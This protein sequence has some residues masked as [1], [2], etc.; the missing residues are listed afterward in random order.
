VTEARPGGDQATVTVSLAVEPATAFD[1]FTQ[2]ID[3]WWGRG[4]AY[5]IFGR[6]PGVLQFERRVGGRL[7]EIFETA[8][9]PQLVEFGRINVWNPPSR[10]VFEWR[11]A[12]FAPGE[13]T[14]VE[15][16]FEPTETGTRVTL[17]HRG[18]ASL[19]TGHPARHGLEGA[20]ISRMIGMWWGELLSSMREHVEATRN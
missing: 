2:E 16:I 17:Y 3:Q 1:V 4:P 11:N 7:F 13:R 20:A 8:S 6:S 5:R 15:V 12:N 19:R 9:G 14:E 18:W 10:L